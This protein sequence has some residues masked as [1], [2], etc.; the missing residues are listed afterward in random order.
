MQRFTY[1]IIFVIAL[2]IFKAFFLDEYLEERAASEGNA[3]V[4]TVQQDEPA[5]IVPAPVVQTVEHEKNVSKIPAS[6][7]EKMP[8]DKLGDSLTKHI[9]L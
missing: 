2:L 6:E 4:E 3:S 5:P 7:K 9:N 8:L 1:L